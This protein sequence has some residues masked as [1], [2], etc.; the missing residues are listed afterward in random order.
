MDYGN[1]YGLQNGSVQYAKANG[2]VNFKYDDHEEADFDPLFP[3][4]AWRR[5]SL[6][7]GDDDADMRPPEVSDDDADDIAAADDDD[8][9]EE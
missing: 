6:D 8:D 1:G 5:L 7:Y 9:D 3:P 2:D 4:K